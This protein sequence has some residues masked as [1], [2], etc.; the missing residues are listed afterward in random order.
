MTDNCPCGTG[1]QPV[2][3]PGRWLHPLT[4]ATACARRAS[5]FDIRHSTFD[6]LR[7]RAFSL[8]EIVTVIV[9]ISALAWIA[10]PRIG[11]Y[12]QRDRLKRAAFR[13]QMDLRV[14][15]QEA[16]RKRTAT[17]VTFNTADD[18]YTLWFWDRAAA[19]PDWA[20]FANAAVLRACGSDCDEA[21][22]TIALGA[23]PDYHVTI[24]STAFSKDT[25][26]FDMY[27]VPDAGGSIVLGSGVG[28]ITVS[29][30]P[31]SG[32]ATTSDPTEAVNKTEVTKDRPDV[33]DV[34]AIRPQKL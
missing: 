31:I 27:G 5:A 22:L 9:I 4:P 3:K 26:T 23:D 29:V 11:G 18:F 25:I 30:D 32:V 28:R 34:V 24:E 15:Q 8:A 13:V 7:R 16:M 12:L 14:A 20:A 2:N 33:D 10:Q 17:S 21:S 1:L 6:I 19:T